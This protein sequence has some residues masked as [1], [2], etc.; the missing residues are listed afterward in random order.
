MEAL[1]SNLQKV[2]ERLNTKV[3]QK[4]FFEVSSLH[5]CWLHSHQGV[6]LLLTL[7]YTLYVQLMLN[8]AINK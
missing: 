1:N 4:V 7:F 2:Y 8:P 5:G 6:Y 3:L